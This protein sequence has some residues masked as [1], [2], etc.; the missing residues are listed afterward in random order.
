MVIQVQ[1]YVYKFKNKIIDL[2]AFK[3]NKRYVFILNY[4]PHNGIKHL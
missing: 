2:L 3:L 4:H 1:F